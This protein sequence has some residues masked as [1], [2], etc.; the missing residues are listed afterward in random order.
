MDPI[1]AL[2]RRIGILFAALFGIMMIMIVSL[3][4]YRPEVISYEILPA[5]EIQKSWNPR[6]INNPG[7]DSNPLAQMGYKLVSQ[8]SNLMGPKASN[9][10]D[11]Y[12]G[13][14]LSCTNCHLKGG[15]QAGSAS[16]VGVSSRF[17]Q[18]G[19]RS[20][21]IGT[22]EDRINGCME[23]S[24]NGKKLPVDSNFM[25]AIVAYMDWLGADL[26]DS[27]KQKYAGYPPLNLPER[28]VDLDA[29]REVYQRT[30]A[31]CH[32]EDGS[33]MPGPEGGYLYPPLWGPDSY[34]DGAGMH[35]VITAAEFIRSNMP[36]GLA[37]ADNPQLSDAEAY[38][39]AGYI[40][41]FKRPHKNNTEKDYPDLTLKPVSTPYGPW[42]DNFTATEHKYGPFQPIMAYYKEKYNIVKNK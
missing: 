16:W 26:P 9:S 23:R 7:V 24:M 41:S 34:N 36:F 13:N 40:N 32:R 42:S 20:N 22:I 1:K 15:T 30:C 39:V 4:N 29:G 19:G 6:D 2:A 18:F 12:T 11:R 8:S 17:P 5:Q 27:Q 35:R 33:G 10:K 37:S 38:D 14:N 25:K 3:I 31:V 21:R 28:A